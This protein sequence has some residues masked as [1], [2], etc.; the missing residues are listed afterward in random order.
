MFEIFSKN[1]L[2]GHSAL[3]WS[4]PPMGVAFG[5]FIPVESYRDIQRE[6]Q[7]NREDQS[8]LALN[9]KTPFGMQIPCVGVGILDFSDEFENDEAEAIEVSVFGIPFPLYEEL[10]P[11]HVAAYDKRWNDGTMTSGTKTKRLV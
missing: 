11:G 7:P 5:K 6:C 4:D 8:G 1:T 9:V 3:E 2:V 10:F